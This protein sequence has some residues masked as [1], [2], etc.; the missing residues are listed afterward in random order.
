M[1]KVKNEC[2]VSYSITL[3]I[4]KLINPTKVSHTAA[5]SQAVKDGKKNICNPV[6][7]VAALNTE[8]GLGPKRLL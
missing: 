3:L 7:S 4:S 5:C 2:S 6:G 8:E 1:R